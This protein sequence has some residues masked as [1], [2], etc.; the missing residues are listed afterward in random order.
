MTKK[1]GGK[2]N[3]ANETKTISIVFPK[4]QVDRLRDLSKK[5]LQSLGSLVRLAVQ[6][7]LALRSL[8]P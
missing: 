3:T 8:N 6:E 1:R 2:N 5:N 4:D 7:F